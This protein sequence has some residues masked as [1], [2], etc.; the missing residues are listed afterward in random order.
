MIAALNSLSLPWS[1]LF[2]FVVVWTLLFISKIILLRLDPNP[3]PPLQWLPVLITALNML[4]SPF[5]AIVVM[6]IGMVF[7]IA[8]QKVNI[9]NDAATGVIGAGIGMLTSQATSA[10]Q[11]ALQN[12]LLHQKATTVIATETDPTVPTPPVDPV[13]PEGK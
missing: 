11:A 3:A 2:G 8:C 5:I 1:L 6:I 7:D 10:A 12:H 9:S 4:N 13:Q